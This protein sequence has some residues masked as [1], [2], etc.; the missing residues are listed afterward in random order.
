MLVTKFKQQRLDVIK[1]NQ[2]DLY[3]FI[4]KNFKDEEP[5]LQGKIAGAIIE[6]VLQSG[7]NS[8]IFLDT[9]LETL[10]EETEYDKF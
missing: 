10:D 9:T 8:S 1:K 6:F 7:G 2:P 3:W 4:A 5:E